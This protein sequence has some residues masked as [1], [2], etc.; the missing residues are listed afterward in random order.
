MIPA[1]F[2]TGTRDIN[3]MLDMICRPPGKRHVSHPAR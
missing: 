3:R 2:S 1:L